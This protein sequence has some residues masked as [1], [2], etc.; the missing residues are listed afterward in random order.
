MEVK[1]I[2]QRIGLVRT[3]ANISARELSLRMGMSEQYVSKLESGKINLSIRKLLD[4]LT[5]CDFP[6]DKFFYDKPTEYDADKELLSQI[7][8]LPSDAKKT[9]LDLIA[10]MK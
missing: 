8:A 1:D 7:K 5:I 10:K 2:V 3:S 4:I 9:I 6:I